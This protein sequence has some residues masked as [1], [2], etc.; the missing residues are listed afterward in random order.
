MKLTAFAK[1]PCDVYRP[2][3]KFLL[4]GEARIQKPPWKSNDD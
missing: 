4:E 1:Y 3:Y 2:S